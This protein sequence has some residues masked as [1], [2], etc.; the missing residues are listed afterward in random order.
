MFHKCGP[1]VTVFG[2]AR[3]EENHQ[4]Y[5]KAR[6]IGRGLATQGWTVITGGGPGIMEAANR[7][8]FEAGGQSYGANIILPHE[9]VPNPYV[10]K[11]ITF[12]Y[13][14]VRKIILIKYSSAFIVMPGGFGTLDELAEALT[15]IQTGKLYRFPVILVGKSYWQG[16]IDWMLEVL[17]PQKTIHKDDLKYLVLTDD[18]E[19]VLSLTQSTA[20]S[21]ELKLRKL[22]V[23]PNNE[24]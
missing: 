19:E 6:S 15:L 7:G 2:S 17:V 4:Y 9:Q 21:L 1:A 13:F 11:S 16:L 24:N 22:S 12:N 20:T 18:I 14:F 23:S 8:A 5:E 10:Q 3:F